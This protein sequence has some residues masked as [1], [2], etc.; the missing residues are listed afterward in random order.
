MCVFAHRKNNF[1]FNNKSILLLEG[2]SASTTSLS[3]STL[4]IGLPKEYKVGSLKK[5]I[6][7]FIHTLKRFS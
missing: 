6:K 7:Y 2:C 3:I 5:C 1:I 4:Q